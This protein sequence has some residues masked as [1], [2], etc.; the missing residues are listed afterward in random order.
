MSMEKSTWLQGMWSRGKYVLNGA[1]W[2]ALRRWQDVLGMVAS[3]SNKLSAK[4]KAQ[5]VEVDLYPNS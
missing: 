5:E 1:T 3:V 2:A 4:C